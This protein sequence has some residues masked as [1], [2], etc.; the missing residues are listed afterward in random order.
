MTTT[1]ATT[2]TIRFQDVKEVAMGMT[3]EELQ[4]QPINVS[5]GYGL[6]ELNFTYEEERNVLVGRPIKGL[7]EYHAELTIA[8]NWN[9]PTVA[10]LRFGDRI[11]ITT[12]LSEEEFNYYVRD[13]AVRH[14]ATVRRPYHTG[15]MR[16]KF[17]ETLVRQGFYKIY[18]ETGHVATYKVVNLLLADPK[19]RN[20]EA[21]T[22]VTRGILIKKE[23]YFDNNTVTKTRYIL[24]KANGVCDVFTGDIIDFNRPSGTIMIDT[25]TVIKGNTRTVMTTMGS[26]T[27]TIDQYYDSNNATNTEFMATSSVAGLRALFVKQGFENRYL[28]TL[29]HPGR[30]TNYLPTIS[31]DAGTRVLLAE[32]RLGS[33][34]V[35]TKLRGS[36]ELNGALCL[37]HNA[38]RDERVQVVDVKL[39]EQILTKFKHVITNKTNTETYTVVTET[40]NVTAEAIKDQGTLVMKT[41]SYFNA[42]AYKHEYSYFLIKATGEVNWWSGANPNFEMREKIAYL[43]FN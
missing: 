33:I 35:S 6:G 25:K 29:I 34:L 21:I 41:I 12:V 23:S 13:Q 17:I 28:A 5:L 26:V 19:L 7:M 38:Q 16:I 1:T 24:I 4:A 15:Q 43:A 31:Y 18:S 39:F 40:V 11:D 42:G 9:I 37:R 22:K 10:K 30:P 3:K 36:Q 32:M 8:L 20:I 27:P 2:Q 14:N